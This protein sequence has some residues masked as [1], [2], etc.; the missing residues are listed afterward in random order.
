MRLKLTS[1]DDLTAAMRLARFTNRD[2]AA[3]ANI[4]YGVVANLR[5]GRRTTCTKV[6]AD[7]IAK[8]VS[9]PTE[10]LFVALAV[11]NECV[12]SADQSGR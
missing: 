3:A 10:R 2:L 5:A 11:S 12:T 4:G 6:V 1:T 9:L 7:R 8:A